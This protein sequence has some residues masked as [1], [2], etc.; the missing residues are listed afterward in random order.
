MK[1]DATNKSLGRLASEVA[2]LLMGKNKPTYERHVK[3]TDKVEVI[4]ASKMRISGTKLGS[5]KYI[6]YSGYPGGQKVETM[7]QFVGKRG[8]AKLLEYTVE[9]M[10]PRNK[11]KK[12]M[13]TNLTVK[14]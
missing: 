3:P 9:G 10:L 5:K 6:R 1:I 13:M 2:K 4:N 11:L 12:I 14:E 7:S 8:Y